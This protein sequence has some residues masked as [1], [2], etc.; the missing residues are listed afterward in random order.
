M[1]RNHAARGGGEERMIIQETPQTKMIVD[2]AKAHLTK[3]QNVREHL[4]ALIAKKL[5]IEMEIEHLRK[6]LKGNLKVSETKLKASLSLESDQYISPDSPQHHLILEMG[7]LDI[8]RAID[9]NSLEI[10]KILEEERS[11]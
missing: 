10:D 2:L 7:V 3:L 4:N 11:S 6:T 5:R 1:V 8:F 9:Q